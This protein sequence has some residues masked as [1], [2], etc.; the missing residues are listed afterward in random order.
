MVVNLKKYR[1]FLLSKEAEKR[2]L[3]SKKEDIGGELSTL[4]Q[5]LSDLTEAQ[6]IMNAVGVLAQT[7]VKE[8][9]E[10]LVT[11]ALQSIYGPEYSFEIENAVL[12]NQPETYF[13]V[14]IN[15]VRNSLREELGG[16]VV[17][18]VGFALRVILWA[19]QSARTDNILILDEPM[20]NLRDPDRLIQFGQLIREISSMLNLQFV[21]NSNEALLKEVGDVV[22]EVSK[23]GNESKVVKYAKNPIP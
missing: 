1:D 17:D 7:E 10:S 20:R 3:E 5:S 16:G 4:Q 14:V 18:T 13:Y 22:F 9:I 23:F 8:V 11:K 19:L 12:R 15:G 2:Y 6:D 21:I